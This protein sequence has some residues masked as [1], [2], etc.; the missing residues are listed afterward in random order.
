MQ[1]KTFFTLSIAIGSAAV[2]SYALLGCGGGGGWRTGHRWP[3]C[4]PCLERSWH[5]LHGPGLFRD[6]HFASSE[7]VSHPGDPAVETSHR[8]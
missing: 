3:V 8:S 2:W 4:G 6:L 5:A 1:R 7:H